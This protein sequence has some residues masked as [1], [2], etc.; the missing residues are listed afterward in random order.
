MKNETLILTGAGYGLEVSPEAETQKAEL[1]A[2]ASAIVEVLDPAGSELARAEVKALAAMRNLVEK[3]RNQVKAPVL[4]VGKDID[5]KAAE[6]VAE[7]KAEETRLTTLVG[8][9]AAEV[10]RLRQKM[11]REIEEKRQAEAK[12]LREAEEARLKAEREAEAAK[13]AEEEAMWADSAEDQAKAKEAARVAEEAR[14]KA[15]A[16]RSAIIE[17]KVVEIVPA[18]ADGT[19]FVTDFEVEDL[20]ALY[21]AHP[22]LC[23]L[24]IRT[25]DVKAH[26]KMLEDRGQDPSLPGLKVFRKPVVSTR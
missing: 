8:D 20:H 5:A 3:S 4:Q 16:E 18:A 25:A 11:L 14:A 24:T 19:K 17:E 2:S 10:E 26:L 9:Y 23:T 6:F 1:L 12:A 13:Q 21:I 22:S 15:E 7:I